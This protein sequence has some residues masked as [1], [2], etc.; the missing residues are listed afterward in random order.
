MKMESLLLT[1]NRRGYRDKTE[2]GLHGLMEVEKL[3]IYFAG[4]Q[5]Q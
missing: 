2:Q 1:A 3:D 4:H 5:V